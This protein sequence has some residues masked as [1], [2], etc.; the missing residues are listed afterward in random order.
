MADTHI[1]KVEEW[2]NGGQWYVGDVSNL[3]IGSNLWWYGPAA[4]NL[5]PI[6]YVKLLITKFKVSHIQY[7]VKSDVLIFSF[8]SLEDCR[9][10]KNYINKQ[11]R[12]NK[13]YIY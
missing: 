10:Y 3:A 6:E 7:K 12:Q 5:S 9:K 13:F 1:Y 8:D 2:E 11:A 4:A